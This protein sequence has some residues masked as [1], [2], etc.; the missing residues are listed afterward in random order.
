[1][2]SRLPRITLLALAALLLVS[3]EAWGLACEDLPLMQLR[4]QDGTLV[5]I[6][7]SDDQIDETERWRVEKK[8]APPLSLPKALKIAR[9]WADKTFP[10]FDELRIGRISLN[11]R[12]CGFSRDHWFYVFDFDPVKDGKV[13]LGTG[14]FVAVLMDGT[15]LPPNEPPGD[16]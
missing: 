9:R 3:S 2:K 14:H 11:E 5:R 8:S 10:E 15:V 6:F 4:L 1:M 16:D 13:Q 12:R 7:A